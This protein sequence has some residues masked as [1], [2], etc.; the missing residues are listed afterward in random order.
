MKTIIELGCGDGVLINRLSKMYKNYLLVGIELS[1]EK[2][3]NSVNLVAAKNV[4][5][6]N[7][8]FENIVPKLENNSI[9]K[10]LAILPDP[11]YIDLRNQNSWKNFY[12]KVFEKLE[13]NGVLIIITE[14]T[15]ELLNPVSQEQYNSEINKIE[16]IFR[17]I[18][19]KTVHVSHNYPSIYSTNLLKKF[20]KDPDRIKIVFYKF[21]K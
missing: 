1:N 8:S 4:K 18:G 15:N 9:D 7:D 14:I 12:V 3:Q 5:L 13:K 19:F 21:L 11:K 16:H 17:S 10:F 20:S 2:F 6:I